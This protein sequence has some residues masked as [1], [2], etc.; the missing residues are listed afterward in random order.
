MIRLEAA[1]P[2]K[3]T[4]VYLLRLHCVSLR[5][6]VGMA[7]VVLRSQLWL[8]MHVS[9]LRMTGSRLQMR[10]MGVHLRMELRMNVL[11]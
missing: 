2:F 1:C 9:M 5:E 3:G 6:S 4:G 8:D 11:M 10:E 7:H